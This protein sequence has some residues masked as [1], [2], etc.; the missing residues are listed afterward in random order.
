MGFC[1]S[2]RLGEIGSGFVVD[3]EVVGSFGS[4]GYGM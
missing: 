1:G 2:G 4:E 3:L